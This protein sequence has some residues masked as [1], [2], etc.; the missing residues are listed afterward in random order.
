H[1]SKSS[2]PMCT[3]SPAAASASFGAMAGKSVEMRIN[4]GNQSFGETLNRSAQARIDGSL[5]L[6]DSSFQLAPFGDV[7]DE[8][9]RHTDGATKGF[10]Q[11]ASK[12]HATRYFP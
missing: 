10:T 2:R 3:S 9:R 1:P 4:H 6:L 12:S 7:R 5:N 8:R 11:S